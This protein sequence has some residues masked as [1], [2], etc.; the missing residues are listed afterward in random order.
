[1]GGQVSFAFSFVLGASAHKGLIDST[2]DGK[3]NIKQEALSNARMSFINKDPGRI[4]ALVWGYTSI[5][6]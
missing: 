5:L 4:I 6:K 1:M 2:S 3:V